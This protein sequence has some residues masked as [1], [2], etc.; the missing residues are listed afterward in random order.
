MV[1]YPLGMEAEDINL[2]HIRHDIIWPS[3]VAGLVLIGAVVIL[4]KV[5]LWS[6][7]CASTSIGNFCTKE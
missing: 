4:H 3:I 5:S 7:N 6:N 2:Y 1:L